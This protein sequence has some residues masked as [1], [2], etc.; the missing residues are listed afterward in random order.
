MLPPW[1][2]ALRP[3]LTLDLRSLALFRVVVALTLLCDAIA[4]ADLL[5]PFFTDAG[6]VPRALVSTAGDPARLSLHMV[7]GALGVQAVLWLGQILAAAALLVGWHSRA[8]AIAAWLLGL[9]ACARDPLIVSAGDAFLVTLL[10]FGSFVPLGARFSLDAVDAPDARPSSHR[11]AGFGNL[12]LLLAIATAPAIAALAQGGASPA[13]ATAALRQ[14]LESPAFA[15]APGTWLLGMPG[16]LAAVAAVALV[17]QFLVP[18]ATLLPGFQ[19]VL[20][21]VALA[22]GLLLALGL[23]LAFD[24]GPLVPAALAAAAVLIDGGLWDALAARIAG[25]APAAALR[26][27]HGRE[28]AARRRALLL[29]EFLALPACEVLPAQDS[30]RVDRLMQ[31]NPGAVVLDRDEAAHL[32][33]DAVA[34]LAR[35]SP[36]AF[37]FAGWIARVAARPGGRA[38]LIRFTDPRGGT[39]APSRAVSFDAANAVQIGSLAL[40]LAALAAQLSSSG[41]PARLPGAL[42]TPLTTLG[43][44]RGIVLPARDLP[45]G[46]I[47]ASGERADGQEVDALHRLDTPPE[48]GRSAAQ[49]SFRWRLYGLRLARDDGA[50]F[51]DAWADSLCHR[52]N[53]H[54]PRPGDRLLRLRLVVVLQAN[55][56]D[57]PE[58]RVLDRHECGSAPSIPGGGAPP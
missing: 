35:R 15:H 3:V 21:R 5:R 42:R 33:A 19:P 39:A 41:Q 36:L 55:G 29:R 25:P 13:A 32:G 11:H 50:P 8:A 12:A 43:L 51:R 26:L 10:L 16:P 23:A 57:A 49:P 22:A 4:H 52:W 9:S 14:A 56:S 46:W 20:R 17:L 31:A 48:Y 40:A 47:V 6:I 58:Q 24:T 18:V 54:Q 27:Y 45:A 38:A 7:S 44:E 37:P 2:A 53:A 28:P 1:A 30:A 34:L